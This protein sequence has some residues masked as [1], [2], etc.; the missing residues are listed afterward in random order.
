MKINLKSKTK[1][2][3]FVYID[4]QLWGT[5]PEGVLHF[6][7]IS[8]VA[9]SLL[10]DARKA[11]LI[12]EIEKYNW[13]KLLDFIAY[14]ERSV[15]E[16]QYFLH[17]QSLPSQLAE[18]LITTARK[19]NYV[20]DRRFAEMYVQDL[21]EKQKSRIQIK[22]K[23]LE[24]HIASELAEEVLSEFMTEDRKAELLDANYQKAVNRFSQ[25]PPE[26]R[27]EKILN[28]LSGKGFSVSD[29]LDK[30]RKEGY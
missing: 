1:K 14:R 29:V 27:R 8:V 9:E 5:L 15:W 3:F 16:C 11:E 30:M 10:P 22:A 23:L 4:D 24:K 21:L 18:K 28:Y 6:F 20:N 19:N 12:A 7:S 13:Q 26:K 17:G 2:I 25:I